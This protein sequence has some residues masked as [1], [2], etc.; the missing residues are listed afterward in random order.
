MNTPPT[1]AELTNI[2]GK[3]LVALQPSNFVDIR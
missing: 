1:L 2:V 3:L